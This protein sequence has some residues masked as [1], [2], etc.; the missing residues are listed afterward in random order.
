MV[1]ET[2]HVLGFGPRWVQL[3]LL[4]QETDPHFTGPRAIAAFD[5]AGGADYSGAKVPTQP[6]QGHWRES[7]F[8]S[9]LMTSSL[10]VN[11]REPLSAI[12]LEALVDMGY[13]VDLSFAD[14]YEL[15][16]PESDVGS[17]DPARIIN[18]ADDFD[19]G[20]V[21]VIDP[22]GR[23]VRI[24]TPGGTGRPPT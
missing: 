17:M 18:L 16:G 4:D 5:A 24:I 7:V 19:R 1:H 2:T 3:N 10:F 11:R 15:D 22:R 20:P 13:H 8:G 21:V 9:E 14:D 12:T 23:T 6:G